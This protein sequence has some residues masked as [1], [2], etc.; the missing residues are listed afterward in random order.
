MGV[1]CILYSYGFGCIMKH[2][3]DIVSDPESGN[4]YMSGVVDILGSSNRSPLEKT[5]K[6]WLGKRDKTI[7]YCSTWKAH[8]SYI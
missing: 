7:E 4:W 2:F 5:L 6:R 8:H 1:R 3:P